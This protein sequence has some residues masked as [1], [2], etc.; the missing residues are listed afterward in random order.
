VPFE[1]GVYPLQEVGYSLVEFPD[2]DSEYVLYVENSQGSYIARE[3]SAEEA[4]RRSPVQYR[5]VFLE[6][7]QHTSR[8]ET[9]DLL[10]DALSGL[11][12]ADQAE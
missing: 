10:Q 4:H 11:T 12:P 2:P 6:M 1:L 3:G 9:L 8:K 5:E 7:E